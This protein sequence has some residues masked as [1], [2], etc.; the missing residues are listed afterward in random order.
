[1]GEGRHP[2]DPAPRPRLPDSDQRRWR[3]AM[4]PG[5]PG[6]PVSPLRNES[7]RKPLT[8]TVSREEKRNCPRQGG[9]R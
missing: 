6:M 9:P 3:T 1:V 8:A 7:F 4:R 5:S 2:P